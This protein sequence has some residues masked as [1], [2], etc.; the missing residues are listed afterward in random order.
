MLKEV[1]VFSALA[2]PQV[3][4]FVWPDPHFTNPTYAPDVMDIGE[5]KDLTTPVAPEGEGKVEP[6]AEV[7]HH[8]G[9]GGED[10]LPQTQTQAPMIP[11]TSQAS[12]G[13]LLPEVRHQV[14]ET[15]GHFRCRVVPGR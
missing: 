10:D 15:R 3:Q 8:R 6:A 5:E 4:I 9:D 7:E 11:H 2:T 14:R 1:L 12:G 13:V